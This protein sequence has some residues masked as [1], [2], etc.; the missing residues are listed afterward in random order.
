MQIDPVYFPFLLPIFFLAM[1]F[2][3]GWALAW[4]GGWQRLTEKYRSRQDFRG[5]IH[6]FV[7]GSFGWVRYRSALRVGWSEEGIFFSV[8]FL[9]RVGHDPL[10]IPWEVI[11]KA[12]LK[13]G[14]FGP[15]LYLH[16]EQENVRI[17]ILGDEAKKIFDFFQQLP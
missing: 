16:I 13:K 15:A 17:K 4:V 11:Q 12:E 8:F 5:K 10:L 3:A 2:V 7:S 6:S 9:S 14:F 1:F